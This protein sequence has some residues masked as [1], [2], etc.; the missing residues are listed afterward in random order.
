MFV[1]FWILCLASVFIIEM[2]RLQESALVLQTNA[3]IA[4]N[5]A[6]T[7]SQDVSRLT[8]DNRKTEMYNSIEY[9]SYL[10][11]MK[12]V[13]LATDDMYLKIVHAI[14][15]ED[16]KKVKEANGDLDRDLRYTPL[17][18]NL[19]YVSSGMLTECYTTAMKVMC[20][21]TTVGG[22]S[23]VYLDPNNLISSNTSIANI[24]YA[25]DVG[26]GAVG[27]YSG[28][29]GS[30]DISYKYTRMTPEIVRSIY[31]S[32]DY[33]M[34]VMQGVLRETDESKYQDLRQYLAGSSIEDYYVPQYT[35]T[36]KTDWAYITGSPVLNFNIDMSMQ[37]KLTGLKPA[38][39]R[40]E[41][42]FCY[43]PTITNYMDPEKMIVPEGQLMINTGKPIS[44]T[45]SY[46]IIG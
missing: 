45:V 35:I 32:E 1:V 24:S 9:K 13:I 36:F 8:N 39:N 41:G 12:D 14:L 10:D 18:F 7:A 26:D 25:T 31:G 15:E 42:G 44:T 19:P 30:P 17:S 33:F 27:K 4:S 34:N 2:Y 6:L 46:N 16:Y 3:V 11:S 22:T 43:D 28:G 23:V 21:G 38:I 37:D 29:S 5:Y 20:E 40:T